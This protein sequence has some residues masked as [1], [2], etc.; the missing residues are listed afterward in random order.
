MCAFGGN[1]DILMSLFP[2]GLSYALARSIARDYL[3]VIRLLHSEK[4]TLE[5][6]KF[7][8]SS[9]LLDPTFQFRQPFF[10]GF[11]GMIL[12]WGGPRGYGCAY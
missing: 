11:R 12:L 6:I 7:L 2:Q 5:G 8:P 9:I 4:R 1:L 10:I 3:L